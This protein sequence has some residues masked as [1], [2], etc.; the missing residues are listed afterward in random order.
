MSNRN[1]EKRRE[2]RQRFLK[3]TDAE[4]KRQTERLAGGFVRLL[5]ARRQ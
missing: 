4:H 5:L 2:Y 3:M 1:R